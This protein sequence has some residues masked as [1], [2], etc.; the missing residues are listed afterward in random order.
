MEQA[1][2]SALTAAKTTAPVLAPTIIYI[3]END[4]DV[5][6][7]MVAAFIVSTISFL[8][9]TNERRKLDRGIP[10]SFFVWWF[11]IL[12][13]ETFMFM[14]YYGLD[15]FMQHADQFPN[16]VWLFPAA[17]AAS[18]ATNIL[19]FAAKHAPIWIQSYLKKKGLMP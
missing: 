18:Y 3:V 15:T 13:G 8:S 17:L 7:L 4:S 6:V 1:V 10:Y 2:S 12:S 19:R 11:Y 14:A 9:F 5:Q 16:V